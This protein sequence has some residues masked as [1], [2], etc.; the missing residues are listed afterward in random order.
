[1]ETVKNPMKSMNGIATGGIATG[2]KE[3]YLAYMKRL[4]MQKEQS[5][6]DSAQ[7]VR[8][9]QVERAESAYLENQRL[10]EEAYAKAA[11]D[12]GSRMQNAKRDTNVQMAR[13][14][15]FL[16]QMMSSQGLTGGVAQSTIL[17]AYSRAASMRSDADRSYADAILALD[18]DKATADTERLQVRDNAIG[19]AQTTYANA[20]AQAAAQRASEEQTAYDTEYQ[21]LYAE[22]AQ[23]EYEDRQRAQE[24]AVNYLGAVEATV[25]AKAAAGYGDDG[26]LSP[27][28]WEDLYAWASKQRESMPQAQ[29]REL[30]AYLEQIRTDV[31]EDERKDESTENARRATYDVN[32]SKGS[33]TVFNVTFGDGEKAKVQSAGYTN[34][35]DVLK[36]A[37]SVKHGEAFCM[38]DKVFMKYNDRVIE[39]EAK[40]FYGND[41]K[42]LKSY[43]SGN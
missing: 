13:I 33:T 6:T 14:E 19:T 9:E 2:G 16:P 26:K 12:Y 5:T 40:T 23:K 8:D 4:A 15:K 41:F 22:A 39:I 25:D 35:E 11:A 3:D 28:A 43:L 38:K 17:D 31:R 36:A 37:E 42:K 27:E 30:D 21:R 20:L 32:T 10:A 7:T 24:E 18:R 1:M 29:Q 34:D